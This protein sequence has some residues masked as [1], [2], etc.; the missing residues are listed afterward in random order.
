MAETNQQGVAPVPKSGESN[1]SIPA[2]LQELP[3]QVDVLLGS[4]KLTVKELLECGP[5]SVI[6]IGKKAN[7]PFDLFVNSVLVAR[8]EVVMMHDRLGLKIIEVVDA[9][10]LIA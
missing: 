1:S 2:Y 8:G 9:N 5:G 6:D 7:E 3:V 4:V 10:A